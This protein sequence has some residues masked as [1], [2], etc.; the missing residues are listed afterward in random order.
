MPRICIIGGGPPL[1]GLP[2]S[3]PYRVQ[4]N[5]ESGQILVSQGFPTKGEAVAC[6]RRIVRTTIMFCGSTIPAFVED[7]PAQSIVSL[8]IEPVA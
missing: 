6:A 8:G 4:M 1:P 2:D 7:D 3:W 5:D